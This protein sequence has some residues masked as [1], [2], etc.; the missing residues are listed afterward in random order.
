MTE[1]NPYQASDVALHE[2]ARPAKWRSL[3]WLGM[4]SSLLLVTGLFGLLGQIS[5]VGAPDFIVEP[6]FI[7]TLL[8]AT[9]VAAFLGPSRHAHWLLQLA[10][11]PALAPILM[12]AAIVALNLLF[13]HA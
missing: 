2:A 8:A 9:A 6:G 11:I 4:F 1:S 5:G 10:L 3:S 7:L 13:G 12:L